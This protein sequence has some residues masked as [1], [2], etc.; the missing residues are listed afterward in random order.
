MKNQKNNSLQEKIDK[1]KQLIPEIFSDGKLDIN[2]LE[3]LLNGYTVEKEEKYRFEWWGKR[4]S[5]RLAYLPVTETLIP[6]MEDSKNF[7]E[8]NNLYIEVII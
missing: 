5:Q 7:N 6:K 3:N 4:R 2:E 1:L 8:T